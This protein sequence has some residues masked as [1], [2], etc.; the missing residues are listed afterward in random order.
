[1]EAVRAPAH[2]T[3]STT[4]GRMAAS[5]DRLTAEAVDAVVVPPDPAPL[6]RQTLAYGL[7]GLIVPIVGV[8]TLPIFARVFTRGQYGLVELGTTVMTVALAITDAGLTAAALRGFYD[9]GPDEED[10]RRRVLTTGFVATTALAFA[11]A[12]LMILLRNDLSRWLFQRPDEGGLIVVIAISLLAFNAW[13]YV[14]EVMRVRL[15]AFNYLATALLAAALTT[16][17]GLAGVLALGW[18]VQGVFL[19]AVIGNSVAA[20]YGLIMVRHSLDGRFSSSELR[21]MLAYGLPLVPSALAAWALAL[22]DRIILAR[23]GSLSEVGQYAIANRLAFLLMIGM[24]AFTF[25]LTPFLLATYSKNPEQEKAGRARTLTYLTFILSF[26]G[27]GLTLF[28]K[29]AIEVVA[30]KFDDAYLAVG[31]LALGTAAYGISTL[32][33]TGLAIA[34][35]TARLAA[36]SVACAVVNIGLNFAL[37]PPFGIVGAALATA[38]GYAA[39]AASFY[40]ASQRA[41]R[42]PYQPRKVLGML[43]AAVALGTIGLIPFDS[44]ALALP[45]KLGALAAFIG[46]TWLSG[47]MGKSEFK[48]LRRFAGSMIAVPFARA[49]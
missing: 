23:L 28:A 11:V 31:P 41:Y 1:M 47:T 20:A 43:A 46:F 32:L 45:V 26:V 16:A 42:T 48:E 13:R 3:R 10:D 44:V 33:T 37:I 9:F 12:G 36:L 34:R 24:S 29:E 38:A 35:K 8:V 2:V 40:W 15:M 14:S 25:A 7:T 18:R 4:L 5:K 39:L 17:I 22:V 30:P 21:R 27:L 49:G 6:A 19:A